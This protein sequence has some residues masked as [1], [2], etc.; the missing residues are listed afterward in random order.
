MENI[1]PWGLFWTAFFGCLPATLP[2][3]LGQILTYRRQMAEIRLN[4]LITAKTQD[5]TTKAA[6]LV[7]ETAAQVDSATRNQ[8]STATAAASIAKVAAKEAKENAQDVKF[9]AG[10]TTTAINNL[11]GDVNQLKE[12]VNGY[13]TE[14]MQSAH[15]AGYAMG[16]N[17]T[18]A[19]KV[20]EQATTIDDHGKRIGSLETKLEKVDEKVGTILEIVKATNG[21]RT[22]VRGEASKPK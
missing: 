6:Q 5:V 22:Q 7:T 11:S 17:D 16:V 13:L 4:T 18:I 15:K 2:I 12:I 20:A 9:A 19:V 21:D 1:T 10:T 8:A 14:R 3:M